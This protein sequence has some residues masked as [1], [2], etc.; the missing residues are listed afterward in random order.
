MGKQRQRPFKPAKI[1]DFLRA[2]RADELTLP[3]PPRDLLSTART[4]EHQNELK[5]DVRKWMQENQILRNLLPKAKVFVL[6]EEPWSTKTGDDETWATC[7]ALAESGVLR[8]PFDS[9]WIEQEVIGVEETEIA[10]V[11]GVDVVCTVFLDKLRIKESDTEQEKQRKSDILTNSGME[12]GDIMILKTYFRV[13]YSNQ[14]HWMDTLATAIPCFADK[15]HAHSLFSVMNYPA[16][17]RAEAVLEGK[18]WGENEEFLEKSGTAKGVK[19]LSKLLA[20]LNTSWVDKQELKQK[21]PVLMPVVE[22][23][24]KGRKKRRF[25]HVVNLTPYTKVA[26]FHK[27]ALRR[28]GGQQGDRKKSIPHIRRGH[29]HRYW[30]GPRNDPD[31]RKLVAKFVEATWVNKEPDLVDV[32]DAE[33]RY[34]VSV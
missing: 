6:E 2:L 7:T 23:D 9:M 15:D 20:S 32:Q 3:Y 18:L 33:K 1:D 25:K 31:K 34:K 29:V 12:N 24:K 8:P 27:S 22:T 30:K 19:M 14:I 28:S 13:R 5:A 10:G 4:T 26:S 16:L 17:R 21:C 11:K